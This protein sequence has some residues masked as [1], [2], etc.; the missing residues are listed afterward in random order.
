MANALARSD[1]DKAPPTVQLRNAHDFGIVIRSLEEREQQIEK[2]AKKNEEEGYHREA[3][4]Q[5]ADAAAIR[6]FILPALRG[7]AELPLVTGD[8][9]RQAIADRLRVVV[10]PTVKLGTPSGDKEAQE[11]AFRSRETRLVEQLA[12]Y[13]EHYVAAVAQEAYNAGLA[14]READPEAIA[15]RVVHALDA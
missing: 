12:I 4:T 3:R 2:L 15:L 10:R 11:D 5:H 1:A 9:V 8:H 13:V 7:Q 14:A 6:Q